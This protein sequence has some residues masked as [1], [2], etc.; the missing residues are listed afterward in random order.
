LNVLVCLRAHQAKFLFC[1]GVHQRKVYLNFRAIEQLMET[2]TQCGCPER[3]DKFSLLLLEQM[4][5]VFSAGKKS[6]PFNK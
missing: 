3:T 1:L 2:Q 5:M 6:R 4:I